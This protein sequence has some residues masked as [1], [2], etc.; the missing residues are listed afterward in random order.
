[1][2]VDIDTIDDEDVLK[3]MVIDARRFRLQFFCFLQIFLLENFQ[4]QVTEDFAE[5][6]RI[7]ARMY[8]LR[9]KRLKDFY[10]SDDVMTASPSSASL[11]T[12][13]AASYQSETTTMTTE[14]SMETD[15]D[16]R[17]DQKR[18]SDAQE[19]DAVSEKIRRKSSVRTKRYQMVLNE[20]DSSSSDA[21]TQDVGERA[22]SPDSL[23]GCQVATSYVNGNNNNNNQI[24]LSTSSESSSYQE[25]K[26]S[27]SRREFQE[28]DMLTIMEVT[29]TWRRI[30]EPNQT[31][32]VTQR[33]TL[34]KTIR[35]R[36][37]D[38]AVL[39][40]N[41]DEVID[42]IDDDG[43]PAGGLTAVDIALRRSSI[44]DAVDDRSF[45]VKRTFETECGRVDDVVSEPD[46]LD[47]FPL[48]ADSVEISE[49]DSA[50][51]LSSLRV[52]ESSSYSVSSPRTES[53]P[54]PTA[55]T[56]QVEELIVAESAP[57]ATKTKRIPSESPSRSAAPAK[58]RA[59]SAELRKTTTSTSTTTSSSSSRTGL[60][61]INRSSY[62]SSSS[63][64][65]SKSKLPAKSSP[66]SSSI[67]RLTSTPIKKK[68]STEADESVTE[69]LQ[70]EQEI[71]A[72]KPE[73]NGSLKRPSARPTTPVTTG[74]KTAELTPAR[75]TS[76]V[77]SKV[78][79]IISSTPEKKVVKKD[80]TSTV[81][82]STT[83]TSSTTTTTRKDLGANK[84][85]GIARPA[86]IRTVET[87][88]TVTV[89]GEEDKPWR[90]NAKPQQV[91]S[92]T[93][94]GFGRGRKDLHNNV[95]SVVEKY[96]ETEGCA[97]HGSHPHIHDDHHEPAKKEES[98]SPEPEANGEPEEPL[99]AEPAI[100][101][102]KLLSV[103]TTP[104]T[105]M[106][107]SGGS[108]KL[109]SASPVLGSPSVVKKARSLFHSDSV[110]ESKPEP[111]AAATSPAA[112]ASISKIRSSFE[113]TSTLKRENTKLWEPASSSRKLERSPSKDAPDAAPVV[114]RS[115][116]LFNKSRS[117]SPAKEV[118]VQPEPTLPAP[119]QQP[120]SLVADNQTTGKVI[121]E[122]EDLTLLE[123]MVIIQHPH[124]HSI[125]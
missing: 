93:A 32:P 117:P 47:N 115:S 120:E 66:S 83:S 35:K 21:L 99:V 64:T 56:V 122:I 18:R 7:R 65:T 58:K 116:A 85:T 90:M 62:N 119:V 41:E 124:L 33:V 95:M 52:D 26:S 37:S 31:T 40:E 98:P 22:M 10:T 49:L 63:T 48:P 59:D 92:G 45:S 15:D 71:Q 84:P 36:V 51:N 104:E 38:G 60:G 17:S 89:R 24:S 3:Q 68:I 80:A 106:N 91:K 78:T 96:V 54:P 75:S 57:A 76:S 23:S 77:S 86:L 114:Q 44:T 43:G 81:N 1:M 30:R 12:R 53:L 108:T 70:L 19:E 61:G 82:K 123:N 28:G 5:K 34:T 107:K 39:E 113:S 46:S 50:V 13:S 25:L 101:R 125:T 100:E 2:D 88:R 97:I 6:R 72:E 74:R 14:S 55:F 73:V 105:S 111:V 103:T 118:V 112:T 67:P 11:P 94:S 109:S 20:I 16:G 9:E 79:T 4:W 110:E 29:E 121:E 69:F 8:K 102:P 87:T 27:S 42:D